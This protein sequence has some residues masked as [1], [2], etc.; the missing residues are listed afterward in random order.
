MAAYF[1]A[2]EAWL[3]QKR[4]DALAARRR[5]ALGKDD[6]DSRNVAIR[7]PGFSSLYPIDKTRRCRA[8]ARR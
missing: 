3:D 6:V 7:D 4:V 2:W 8:K 5:I 1:E